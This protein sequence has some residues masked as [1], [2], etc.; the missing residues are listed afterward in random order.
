MY[1]IN[2]SYT[3]DSTMKAIGHLEKI[4]VI[5]YHD[6]YKQLWQQ[7]AQSKRIGI[8]TSLGDSI[9]IRKMSLTHKR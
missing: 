1:N 5:R 2:K 7:R 4:G 6:N 9:G 3:R 8:K